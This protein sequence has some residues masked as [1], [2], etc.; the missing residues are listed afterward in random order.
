MKAF[1][2]GYHKTCLTSLQMAFRKIGIK[3]FPRK[4]IGSYTRKIVNGTITDAE[5]EEMI[6]TFD[7]Y[8]T[9]SD[10]PFMFNL[11]GKPMYE[12]LAER[13]PESKFILSKRITPEKWLDSVYY[14][15]GNLY[16]KTLDKPK[17]YFKYVY[18]V[19]SVIE[20]IRQQDMVKQRYLDY[21]K[22]CEEYFDGTDRLHVFCAEEGDRWQD[23]CKFLG[24]EAPEDMKFPH[25]N[26]RPSTTI[27]ELK[28]I[29][30]EV[31]NGKR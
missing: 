30:E 21:N 3:H 22:Q 31:E 11:Y 17:A 8:E 27:D 14:Y 18:G 13:F 4:I 26:K 28:R 7:G 10:S 12:F 2:I 19:D 23:A 5:V 16:I 1:C 6:A 25:A 9:F 24:V 29:K 15:F 20:L